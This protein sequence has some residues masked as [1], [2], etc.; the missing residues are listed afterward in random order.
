MS[1]ADAIKS[2]DGGD[3]FPSAKADKSTDAE[4]EAM[5]S[6]SR[7]NFPTATDAER[8]AMRRD[9]YGAAQQDLFGCTKKEA[10]LY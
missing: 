9:E 8:L 3:P 10:V 1:G 7:R 4:F 5:L 2:A 6:W